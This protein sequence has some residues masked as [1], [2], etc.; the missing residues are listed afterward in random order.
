MQPWTEAHK[1]LIVINMQQKTKFNAKLLCRNI[2]SRIH[3]T[4]YCII[5]L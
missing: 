5:S 4:V 2:F 3:D 1:E